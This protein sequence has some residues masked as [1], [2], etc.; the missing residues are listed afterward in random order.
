ML[1]FDISNKRGYF[2]GSSTY[3]SHY[4][5]MSRQVLPSSWLAIDHIHVGHRHNKK[6]GMFVE[7]NDSTA[8]AAG[9]S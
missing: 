5:N 1:L 6:G 8:P 2:L 9:W 4:K 3:C 7:G